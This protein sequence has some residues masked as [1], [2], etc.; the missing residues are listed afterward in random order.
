[1]LRLRDMLV[2]GFWWEVGDGSR[3]GFC[4]DIWVVDRTLSELC[5]RLFQLAGNKE[6]MVKE[7]GKREVEEWR[8]QMEWR[9]GRIGREKGEERVLWEVLD[10]IQLKEGVEDCWK[11]KYDAEGRYL[12]K[13]AYDFLDTR[14][15]LLEG[16]ICKL[17]WC[18]LVPSKVNFF[19]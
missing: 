17:V 11:W 7:T 6:V 16:K 19:G 14:E 5:P 3:V 13:K 18:K 2:R 12:V 10:N 8:W 9:R 15:C 4:R 1:M